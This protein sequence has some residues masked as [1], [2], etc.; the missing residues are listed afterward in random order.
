MTSAIHL[1]Q[2]CG[3]ILLALTALPVVAAEAP[4]ISEW[5]LPASMFARALALSPDGMLFIAVPNDNRVVRFDPRAQ[6]LRDW[7]LPP[8]HHPNALAVD[9]NGAV[10][11]AGFG[12]GS[13]GRLR[14]AGGVISEFSTPTPGSGPHSLA[15]SEDG[16]TLWFTMQSVNRI[17][18]L[19][20]ATGRIAEYE[21]SGRPTG[22][23]IDRTGAVWWC[24]SAETRLGR[25]DPQSGKIS[26]LE[27]GR[28]NRPRRIATAPDGML[29]VTIYGRSHV[30]RINPQTQRVLRSYALPA[31]SAEAHSISIDATGI[32]WISEMRND[33]L[34]RLDPAAPDAMQTIRLP[35]AN[36]G[37]SPVLGDGSR[38]W[39][40]GTRSGRFGFVQ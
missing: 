17:G 10:W 5:Q 18:S 25:L 21:D 1:I 15:L 2:R 34:L 40:A 23:T 24:R 7:V 19:D 29:W 38:A 4:K 14:P 9:R 20:T 3:A 6:A 31:G 22:I 27:L 8:G 36:T 30:L 37:V 32:V 11:T 28:G 33:T 12:N 39:Y 16:E 13:I 26:E 35:F